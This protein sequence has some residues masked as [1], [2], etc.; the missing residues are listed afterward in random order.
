MGFVE[1]KAKLCNQDR[2]E[3]VRYEDYPSGIPS[4]FEKA[5]ICNMKCDKMVKVYAVTNFPNTR[6]WRE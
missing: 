3:A 6:D 1:T 2:D 4:K 5:D